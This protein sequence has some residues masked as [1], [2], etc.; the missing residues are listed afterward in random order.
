MHAFPRRKREHIM[1]KIRSKI[2]KT[3]T[4]F[5]ELILYLVNAWLV[6]ATFEYLILPKEIRT[7]TGLDGLAA[8][9]IGRVCIVALV[10]LAVQLLLRNKPTFQKAC[11]WV[12][13]CV[14]AVYATSAVAA[15][16]SWAFFGICAVILAMMVA[17][18]RYRWNDTLPISEKPA[19]E[20]RRMLIVTAVSA[21]AFF[22]IVSIWTVGRIRIF[23]TPTFDFG[24]FA[25]MF[26]NMKNTLIPFTT[27][28][29][30]GVLSHF[31]VHVSPIYYLL[32]PFYCIVPR[33]ETLQVLQAAVLASAVIP[34]WKLGKHHG[35]TPGLRALV[36]GML[37]LYPAFAGGASYDIHENCFLTPLIL[38][39]LYGIDRKNIPLTAIFAA[40]TLMVKEDAAVYVAVIAVYLIVRSLLHK[41][42]WGIICGGAVL[43][44]SIG[45]FLA[46]THYLATQGDGVMNYRYNNFMFNDSDSLFTVIV[47]VI[48]CPLKAV[49]ECVD[50]EKLQFIGQTMLPLL[51]LPLI[52][53]RYER[54]LL[55]IPYVLINLMSDYTY[56]HNIMFQYTFGSTACL[57]YL[58]VVNLAD[59]KQWKRYGAAAVA[60][61]VCFGCFCAC[62]VPS[63][64]K[65]VS[66]DSTYREYY[67]SQREFLAKVPEDA[68]VA[69]TT[70]YTT[71]LSCRETLYD[72][73][74]ASGE[75]ILECEYVVI[76]RG[77]NFKSY[78]GAPWHDEEGFLKWLESNGYELIDELG[79]I[80]QMY[81]RK[82]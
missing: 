55:L 19:A 75:H 17:F 1:E 51:C 37:L 25:Q 82:Q 54:Y 57:F 74:Y 77:A 38:W 50:T 4:T 29:R 13:P 65:V 30:D 72:V 7:L 79:T 35:L 73:Q 41:E 22:A 45:Y 16:F 42:K 61:C 63:V 47:A 71:Y 70:F 5:P 28:E 64:K 34:L 2:E 52:T 14:F 8:M 76:K 23:W 60:I 31:A 46:V 62:I 10:A 81:R 11:P 68:S 24:I 18:A 15:S 12:V 20:D 58:V 21:V 69:A 56:Q 26:H 3:K 48:L 27:V 33:P 66:A 32:L 78:A 9:S 67:D 59:L 49:F 44:A 53:R 39:L 6:A 43:A 80:A 36:C 40:L